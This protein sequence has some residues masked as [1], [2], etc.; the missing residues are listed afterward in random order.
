MHL[1]PDQNW[2]L[3]TLDVFCHVHIF[4][5]L[6]DK[7]L[8]LTSSN[9][10]QIPVLARLISR[11]IFSSGIVGLNSVVNLMMYSHGLF[12]LT[13]RFFV[14]DSDFLSDLL[15]CMQHRGR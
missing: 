11:R 14:S 10:T 1:L 4:T 5:I 13:F 9:C 3:G 8:Y 7:S 2:N 12:T 15:G 6:F